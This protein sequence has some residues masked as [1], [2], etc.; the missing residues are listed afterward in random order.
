M[1][2][3]LELES[4]WMQSKKLE[5]EIEQRKGKLSVMK[6]MEGEDDSTFNKRTVDLSNDLKE[7]I[8]EMDEISESNSN[9]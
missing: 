1:F 2:K 3:I 4:S 8:E 5:L 7:K 6:Q 9:S